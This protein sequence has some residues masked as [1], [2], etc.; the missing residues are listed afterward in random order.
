MYRQSDHLEI[1]KLHVISTNQSDQI[2][3]NIY[4]LSICTHLVHP[5]KNKNKKNNG[6]YIR[7]M[8]VFSVVTF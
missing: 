5:L 7:T 8:L 3:K 6:T 4:L 2:F 1:E